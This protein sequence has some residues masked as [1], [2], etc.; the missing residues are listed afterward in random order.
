MK[1]RFGKWQSRSGRESSLRKRRRRVGQ[2]RVVAVNGESAVGM[3]P[4]VGEPGDIDSTNFANIPCNGRV[5][6]GE[7]KY[8]VALSHT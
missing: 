6:Q 3:L 5:S 7:L 4:D 1:A 2:T 8:R